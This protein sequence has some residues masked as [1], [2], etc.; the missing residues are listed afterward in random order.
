MQKTNNWD[1][2]YEWKVVVLLAL[3]FGLVGMD[4]FVIASLWPSMSADLGLPVEMIATISGYT[5][6]AWGFFAVIFGRLADKWGHRKIIITSV[7]LFSMLGGLTGMAQSLTLLVLIRVLMGATEGAYIP[8]SVTAVAVASKPHRRGMN[9]GAQQC[10]VSLL[11]LAFAPILATQLLDAGVS[12]HSIFWIIALPGFVVAGLLYFVLREPKDTQGAKDLGVEV[13]D[14]SWG[15]IIRSSLDCFKSY[16]IVVCT[17]CLLCT[18]ACL[19]ILSALV[20]VYLIEVISLSNAEMGI[21]TSA[22]GFGGF[23]GQFGWPALS[24]TLGRKTVTIIGFIGASI[25][26]YWFAGVESGVAS[27]FIPLFITSFFCLGNIA[28]ITGPI[29]T[30]SA[31]PGLVAA[32]IGMVIGVGEM[33]GG[34]FGPMIAGKVAATYGLG[35]ITNVALVG[36]VVGIFVSFFLK[37]TAPSKV[38]GPAPHTAMGDE[39]ESAIDESGPIV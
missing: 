6:L 28:V 21:V 20:P 2:A 38:G 35:A 16:N 7:I 23:L 14:E 30:E 18:M 29:A 22:I 5:A 15:Q 13:K 11:G 19:F 24:D 4:R 34:G 17:I 33:C 8:P 31:P 26:V 27:L 37:E 10:L 3:A 1:T 36:V 25:A 9:Q 32:S 39:V 12:W